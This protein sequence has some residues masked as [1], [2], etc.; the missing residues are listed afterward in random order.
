[1]VRH[2]NQVVHLKNKLK[3]LKQKFWTPKDPEASKDKFMLFG[4]NESLYVKFINN[5]G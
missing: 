5:E 3:K 1:M 2:I 4:C